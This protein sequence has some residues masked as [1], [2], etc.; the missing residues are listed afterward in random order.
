MTTDQDMRTQVA[1]ALGPDVESFNVSGIVD[2]IQARYGT[3][4]INTVPD[5]KFW[6]IV[7]AHDLLVIA[8]ADTHDKIM[9]KVRNLDAKL[10]A[11][12]K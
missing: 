2:T 3:V 9:T 10:D 7:A 5:I 1:E 11:A 6:D 12:R 4:D 8:P